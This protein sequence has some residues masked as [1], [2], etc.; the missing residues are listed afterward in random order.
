MTLKEGDFVE[1]DYTGKIK[2]NGLIFDT[3][4]LDVAKANGIH[5]ADFSKAIVKLGE[6]HLLKGLEDEL[7]GKETGDY[8]IELSSEQAFGKKNAKLIA[9]VPTQ[10]F[11]KQQVR[12][13]PGLQVEIDGRVGVVK[14]VSGG[15]TTVDFNHPLA[16][17]DII[18]DVKVH[19]V[20]TDKNEQLKAL[21]KVL[22]RVPDANVEVKDDSATIK[23]PEAMPAEIAKPVAEEFQKLTGIKKVEFVKA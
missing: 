18:Y 17:Q 21:C 19:R 14:T 12:P 7:I 22:L 6:G 4:E 23:L 13:E 8:T 15:R 3:T 1:L 11:L 10:N 9:L 2:D 16:S 20:V 5:G